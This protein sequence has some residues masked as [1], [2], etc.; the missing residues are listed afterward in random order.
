MRSEKILVLYDRDEEYANLMCE[1]LL[2]I[3]G[4]PWKVAAC[5]SKEDLYKICV[6]REPDVLLIAASC[7]DAAARI[8]AGKV[9]F[10]E[11]GAGIKDG[12]VVEKYQA[13]EDT[14][15]K[16]LEIYSLD[17]DVSANYDPEV[18]GD[19]AKLIGFFS[20]VRRCY[21]TTFSVLLGRLLL[22]RGR[23]L[24]LS[25]A[26][27]EGFEELTSTEGI[28]NLSDLMY[29]IKSPPSIFSLRFKSMV[30]TISGLD[31]IP[32]AISGCDIAEI[33][34][35]EWKTFLFRICALEGYSYVILDLSENIHGIFGILRMCDRIY[36]L[37]RHDRVAKRKTENYE[38][39]LKIYKY[40]DILDKSIRCSPPSVNK[41]PSI[42]GEIYGGDFIDYIRDQL[43][44]F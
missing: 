25:F 44:A 40:E 12:T 29:F 11:D 22:E 8:K 4:L 28:K 18:C 33:P 23:V 6:G 15:R 36:T 24:Y 19:K 41:V 20:P 27:C 37:T 16:I 32:A 38:N 17:M 39:I 5:T 30:R 42:T 7:R 21:Q 35:D 10:L 31:Y 26:F 13:A 43:G 1:F 9:I 3:K 14:I 2:G 34:E